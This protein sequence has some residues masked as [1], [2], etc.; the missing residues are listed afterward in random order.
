MY[1]TDYFKMR[2]ISTGAKCLLMSI[3]VH[4]CASCF[5]PSYMALIYLG[6]EFRLEIHSVFYIFRLYFCFEWVT[7]VTASG[8]QTHH[9]TG[10][11]RA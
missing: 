1:T 11:Q 3:H 5:V 7:Y 6:L 9:S 10:R 4:V 2:K 8:G